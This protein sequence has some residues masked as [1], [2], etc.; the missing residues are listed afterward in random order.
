MLAC[1]RWPICIWFARK[2]A[3]NPPHSKAALRAAATYALPCRSSHSRIP[4]TLPV[5]SAMLVSAAP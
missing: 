3:M 5:A 4:R 1:E 2:A